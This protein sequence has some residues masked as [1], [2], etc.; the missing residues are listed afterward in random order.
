MDPDVT[1]GTVVPVTVTSRACLIFA[2]ALLVL[3]TWIAV[4]RTIRT[5][6]LTAERMPTFGA[7]LL[8]DGELSTE[9]AGFHSNC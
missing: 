7:V 3:A 9:P 8:R 1:F 4:S 5:Q 6:I 2:D